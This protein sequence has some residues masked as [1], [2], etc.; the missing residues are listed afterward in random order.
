MNTESQRSL[1][2]STYLLSEHKTTTQEKVNEYHQKPVLIKC[3][4]AKK[5]KKKSDLSQKR[6]QMECLK[7]VSRSHQVTSVS[8]NI[9]IGHVNKWGVRA[10]LQV[11]LLFSNLGEGKRR[12]E[13]A[14]T[15]DTCTFSQIICRFLKSQWHVNNS[16]P[17]IIW[18]TTTITKQNFQD[19]CLEAFAFMQIIRSI[20][21]WIAMRL[22]RV[23]RDLATK[24]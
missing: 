17:W 11:S 14:I 4:S 1:L 5:E 6:M 16:V 10:T 12:E 7:L 13:A 8:T 2:P 19:L 9:K 23:R 20:I 21:I 18:V 24:Q 15:S 3:E 22:Q